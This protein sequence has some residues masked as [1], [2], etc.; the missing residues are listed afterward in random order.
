M[1]C[2]YNSSARNRSAIDGPAARGGGIG[3]A[4]GV[5]PAVD[6]DQAL[7]RRQ[8]ADRADDGE[9]EQETPP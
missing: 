5:D 2:S 4:R 6:P 9:A 8:V 1:S 7:E 3:S